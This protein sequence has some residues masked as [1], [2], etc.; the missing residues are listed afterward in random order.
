MQTFERIWGGRPKNSAVFNLGKRKD[1]EAL[2]EEIRAFFLKST[3]KPTVKKPSPVKKKTEHSPVSL[4]FNVGDKVRM[5]GTKQVGI[6]EAIEKSKAHLLVN[7]MK[8]SVPL[9]KLLPF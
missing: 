8:I 1:N 4:V 9:D 6:I 7:N 3:V 5:V 2:M